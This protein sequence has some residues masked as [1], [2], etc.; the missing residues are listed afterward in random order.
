MLLSSR[1]AC[2]PVNFTFVLLLFDAGF[3]PPFLDYD[4]IMIHDDYT[5]DGIPKGYFETCFNDGRSL[6]K[7]VFKVT[8]RVSHFVT[9]LQAAVS[10]FAVAFFSV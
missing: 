9:F 1:S 2:R 8:F 10:D 7:S 3:V 6:I 4:N 5:N